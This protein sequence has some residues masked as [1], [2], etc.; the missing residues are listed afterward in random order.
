[1]K[2]KGKIRVFLDY[3]IHTEQNNPPQM[4]DY[5][6]YCYKIFINMKDKSQQNYLHQ[7]I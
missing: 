1:M 6:Y 7:A 4:K 2:N 3:I 5:K